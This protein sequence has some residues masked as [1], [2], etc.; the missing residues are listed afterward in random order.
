MGLLLYSEQFY[1]ADGNKFL[2]VH[3]SFYCFGEL[4]LPRGYRAEG[5][6]GIVDYGFDFYARRLFRIRPL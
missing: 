2:N 3:S 5:E 6:G 1:P 4:T